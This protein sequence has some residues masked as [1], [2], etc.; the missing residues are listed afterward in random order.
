MSDNLIPV[1]TMGYYDE[2][3]QKWIPVDAVGLKSND[4]RYTAD[5]IRSKFDEFKKNTDTLRT[6]L[7]STGVSITRFGAKGD[8][9]TDD[10][11]AF[12]KALNIGGKVIIPPGTYLV[13]QLKIN[14]N[15]HFFGSGKPTIKHNLS[16]GWSS[17]F[18]R[19]MIVNSNLP[20]YKKPDDATRE[21]KAGLNKNI[22]LENITFD[23]Q[24]SPIYG[25]QMVAADYVSIINCDVINTSGGLDFRAVRD[26]YVNLHLDNVQEDGISI[27]DQNFKPLTGERG[28]STRVLFEKCLVENSC[29]VNS[30]TPPDAN[31]Y[32]FDDGMSHIYLLNCG[33]INNHGSGFEV[34]VHTSEYDVTDIHFINCFAINNTPSAGVTRTV[35]GFH[36][37]QTPLESKLGRIY[38]ENCTSIGSPNAFAGSP[39]SQEGT[40]DEIFI[41]GGYWEAGNFYE[42]EVRDMRK[43][44]MLLK[45]QFNNFVIKNATIKAPKDGF[46]IY[47]YLEGK[48]LTVTGNSFKD[49]YIAARLG[50]YEGDVVFSDN[51]V[52]PGEHTT[53]PYSAFV[54]VNTKTAIIKD[55]ILRMNSN[56][57][58]S[59]IVR[60]NGVKRSIISGNTIENT[61]ALYNNAIQVDGVGETIVEKNIATNFETGVFMSNESD[62]VIIANNSF[63]TC[64]RITNRTDASFLILGQNAGA[65]VNNPGWI[66]A[67]L[68]NGWQSF[69]TP[70]YTKNGNI[71]TIS[72]AVKSGSAGTAI[73]TLP[74]EYRPTYA[75]TYT[76]YNS[77]TS[78]K[79]V[80]MTINNTGTVVLS[81]AIP[82]ANTDYVLLDITYTL[83]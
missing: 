78:T 74:E 68:E 19:A 7:E 32:E 17:P 72:G 48:D 64:T 40:K 29:L 70:R 82:G 58:S 37:G 76:Q 49:T 50:H 13:G 56:D 81:T 14:S 26:S 2:E 9:V 69:R 5:D 67:Q 83:G 57:Y 59:S 1:N 12:Q 61:G 73:F 46:G 22:I 79:S 47:T 38:F 4:N 60:I 33:A 54:Y 3:A 63:K 51:R 24:N 31:A 53:S 10:T 43:T 44:A 15:T 75:V 6:E 65:T 36:L 30:D 28:I 71:V 23:G 27:S 45:K 34:H 39:G 25:I 66:N 77:G 11:D 18:P 52:E 8:G 55:N 42:N 41:H 62:S 20:T 80:V 35:A 21:Y 16:T